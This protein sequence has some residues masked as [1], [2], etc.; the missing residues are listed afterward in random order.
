MEVA[1]AEAISPETIILSFKNSEN[2]LELHLPAEL[3]DV[4]LLVEV[5]TVL[6]DIVQLGVYRGVVF[7]ATF[8]RHPSI[9]FTAMMANS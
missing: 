3:V 4:R 9:P 5:I 7:A 8:L 6:T 1:G 2:I